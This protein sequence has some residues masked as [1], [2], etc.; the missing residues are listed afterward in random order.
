MKRGKNYL[1]EIVVWCMEVLTSRRQEFHAAD[2]KKLLH[3]AM[4][5]VIPVLMLP[6][7]HCQPVFQFDLHLQDFTFLEPDPSGYFLL[8][9]LSKT[10]STK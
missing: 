4:Q 9:L 7:I 8:K 6:G 1:L 10:G 5:L 3:L 2:L